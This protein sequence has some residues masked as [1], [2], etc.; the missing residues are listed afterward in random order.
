LLG[1]TDRNSNLLLSNFGNLSKSNNNKSEGV[2]SPCIQI[3]YEMKEDSRHI[4]RLAQLSILEEIESKSGLRCSTFYQKLVRLSVNI[5]KGICHYMNRT[6]S[7]VM[8]GINNK[9][10]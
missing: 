2:K 4:L 8:E 1:I 5:T 9:L 7:G 10:S 6:T 3:A